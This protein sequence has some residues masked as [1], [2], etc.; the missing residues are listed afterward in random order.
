[1]GRLTLTVLGF[2][3][4][5]QFTTR[6]YPRGIQRLILVSTYKPVKGGG[7]ELVFQTKSNLKCQGGGA[8]ALVAHT[9]THTRT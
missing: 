7:E 4:S 3:L 1:M 2:S 6:W 9:H 8:G 5:I